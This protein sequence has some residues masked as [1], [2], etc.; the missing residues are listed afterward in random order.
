MASESN[1]PEAKLNR[2][3]HTEAGHKIVSIFMR[4][5][6]K[7]KKKRKKIFFGFIIKLPRKFKRKAEAVLGK[8]DYYLFRSFY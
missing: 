6:E 8:K 1:W 7:K 4:D 2:N 5:L 3:Y